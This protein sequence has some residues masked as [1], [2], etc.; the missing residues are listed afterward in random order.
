[1]IATVEQNKRLKEIDAELKKMFPDFYGSV[2][3]NCN[4]KI[5][6]FNINLVENIIE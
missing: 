4:P 3:F 2:R 1:M 5:K 6:K